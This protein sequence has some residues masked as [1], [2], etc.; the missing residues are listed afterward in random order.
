M[1][2]AGK[3][4]VIFNFILGMIFL[5]YAVGVSVTRYDLS[6]I[7]SEKRG[8]LSKLQAKAGDL[9]KKQGELRERLKNEQLRLKQTTDAVTKQ[10]AGYLNEIEER[11]AELNRLRE[12]AEKQT[13]AI[14][15]AHAEQ[16]AR[17]EEVQK[18][19][20][21]RGEQESRLARL[22]SDK[23][24][25]RNRLAQETNLLHLARQ[26]ADQLIERARQLEKAP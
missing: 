9:E 5:A 19:T 25:L 17:R 2:I 8:E 6:Q 22:E 26:R 18:L 24:D 13:E 20:T 16:K 1:T 10:S 14:K 23:F 7:L 11:S 3:T 12:Q 15:A 21:Q 4:L